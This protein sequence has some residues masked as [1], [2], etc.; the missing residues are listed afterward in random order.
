MKVLHHA[1]NVVAQLKIPSGVEYIGGITGAEIAG[2]TLRWQV[3]ELQPGQ[4]REYNIR[5]NMTTTGSH[6]LAFDCQGTASGA[7]AVSIATKVE[8]VADLVLT[9]NDPTAPAPVNSEVV[10]EILVKNRG[11]KAATDIKAIAQ[12]SQFIEPVRAEGQNAKLVP[13]QVC[14][15]RSHAWSQVKRSS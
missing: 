1:R 11:S 15:I 2:D 7:A 4:N 12:F 14:S 10:Y 13:G 9:V 3:A 8:A 6:L 5:C